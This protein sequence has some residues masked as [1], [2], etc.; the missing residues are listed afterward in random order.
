[1]LHSVI[2]DNFFSIPILNISKWV[3]IKGERWQN[4]FFEE[5]LRKLME[6]SCYN[7][8]VTFFP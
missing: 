3:I 1:M 7:D 8:K 6:K 4:D 2:Y 5:E